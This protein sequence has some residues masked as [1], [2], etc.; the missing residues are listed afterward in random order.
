MSCCARVL[1]AVC[2]NLHV[3]A[4]RDLP[5][6]LHTLHTM[7]TTIS[8]DFFRPRGRNCVLQLLKVIFKIFKYSRTITTV[9]EPFCGLFVFAG[10]FLST[11]CFGE[12]LMQEYSEY[13][14]LSTGRQVPPLPQ[15]SGHARTL[16]KCDC[17]CHTSRSSPSDGPCDTICRPSASLPST[18]DSP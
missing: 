5:P 3:L 18:S 14:H 2:R 16:L 7:N 9:S 4:T 8:F 10:P 13:S 6:L 12:Q 17:Y 15:S 1:E 11:S